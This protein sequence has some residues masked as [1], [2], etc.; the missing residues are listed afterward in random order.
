MERILLLLLLVLEAFSREN[1][2]IVSGTLG[3]SAVIHCHYNHERDRWRKKT[4]CKHVTET[5]CEPIVS[6]RRF[7]LHFLQKRNGS[8]SIADDTTEGILT[9][10][11]VELSREDTGMYQCQISQRDKVITLKKI[12]LDVSD[13]L[14]LHSDS[15]T[16][17]TLDTLKVQRSMSSTTESKHM[18]RVIS[19]LTALLV[20]KLLVILLIQVILQRHWR[21]HGENDKK[22]YTL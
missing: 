22:S 18:Q 4:W 8:T 13:G 1:V 9:V 6:A 20:S 16:D 12:W 19:L 15:A 5:Y 14:G 17:Q 3:H 7:W 21:R 11:I 10:R 2:T